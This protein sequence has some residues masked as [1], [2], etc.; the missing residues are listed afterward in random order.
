MGPK[1]DLR[2][3]IKAVYTTSSTHHST[4]VHVGLPGLAFKKGTCQQTQY[5]DDHYPKGQ[6]PPCE[7]ESV[8]SRKWGSFAVPVILADKCFGVLEF[9]INGPTGP[10]DGYIAEVHKA[11]KKEGFQTS[12]QIKPPTETFVPTT[13]QRETTSCKFNRYKDL[14]PCLGLSKDAAMKM[15]K[16]IHSLDKTIIKNTFGSAHKTAG[17]PYWACVS[18]RTSSSAPKTGISQIPYIPKK[19]LKA[20]RTHKTGINPTSRILKK[21]LKAYRALIF[22]NNEIITELVP[23]DARLLED[24]N[25]IGHQFT[26]DITRIPLN[27]LTECVTSSFGML[28]ASENN[29]FPERPREVAMTPKLEVT[30]LELQDAQVNQLSSKENFD[31]EATWLEHQ[32]A[33]PMEDME[34]YSHLAWI[35]PEYCASDN[36]HNYHNEMRYQHIGDTFRQESVGTLNK[37]TFVTTNVATAED[38]KIPEPPWLSL[39]DFN[40]SE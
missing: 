40:V 19:T 11:L 30:G 29:G 32:D 2:R 31:F 12:I 26:P 34:F 16:K 27:S 35:F 21:N 33:H 39:I 22:R 3:I 20:S 13:R 10:C 6:R 1:K 38:E 8:F 36:Q 37:S 24:T 4:D 18:K 23:K 9:V 28:S 25:E 17:I 14:V 15:A 5:I 7:D